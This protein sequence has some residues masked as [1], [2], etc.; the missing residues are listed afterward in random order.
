MNIL[1]GL[2]TFGTIDVIEVLEYYDQPLFFT[3]RSENGKIL[4]CLLVDE[5]DT[6]Q[7]WYLLE[8][9]NDRHVL[10]HNGFID[11]YTA[12]TTS[13]NGQITEIKFDK[14]NFENRNELKLACKSLSDA[15]LPLPGVKSRA[16][17]FSPEA[18]LISKSKRI[19]RNILRISFN[20]DSARVGEAPISKFAN[21][22]RT[23]QELLDS[24]SQSLFSIPTQRGTIPGKITS[25]SALNLISIGEGSFVADLAPSGEHRLLNENSDLLETF[26]DLFST[27]SQPDVLVKK[28]KEFKIRSAAKYASFLVSLETVAS[29]IEISYANPSMNRLKRSRLTI[30]EIETAIMEINKTEF[31]PPE[32]LDIIGVLVGANIDDLT[33]DIHP[34]QFDELSEIEGRFDDSI[35][36][37]HLIGQKLG[38]RYRF[39]LEKTTEIKASSDKIEDHYKILS[40]TS[41]E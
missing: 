25:L 38:I 40:F 2:S 12:F 11:Y 31:S 8:V 1:P 20:F 32:V 3:G 28:L 4:Y 26:S 35:H 21:V 9:S 23:L 17:L 22:L 19:D 30:Q 36:R 34:E 33:F 5:S 13:E 18:D 16:S 29:P 14:L 39:K 7:T 10:I 27:T 15:F 37:D 41:I 24:I 6:T